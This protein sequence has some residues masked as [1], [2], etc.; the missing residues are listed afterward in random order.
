MPRS[1]PVSVQLSSWSLLTRGCGVELLL[2]CKAGWAE[3][4][5]SSPSLLPLGRFFLVH[6]MSR[7]QNKQ[8]RK[9]INETLYQMMEKLRR[10][11]VSTGNRASKWAN[12]WHHRLHRA[13]I[14][15]P[16]QRT[17]GNLQEEAGGRSDWT[18]D[19]LL[20]SQRTHLPQDA[21]CLQ[22]LLSFFKRGQFSAFPKASV[23][24]THRSLVASSGG[25][26]YVDSGDRRLITLSCSLLLSVVGWR[27]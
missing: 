22:T 14:K 7:C 20:L 9:Q 21:A 17:R 19:R 2:A 11:S 3:R 27:S 25:L 8:E 5:P 16:L 12:E 15:T 23:V 4:L 26:S 13:L 1:P 10:R 24:L 18:A 6:F